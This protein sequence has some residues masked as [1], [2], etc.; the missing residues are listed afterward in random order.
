V[1]FSSSAFPVLLTLKGVGVPVAGRH[2]PDVLLLP[3]T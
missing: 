3:E 2:K 1:R